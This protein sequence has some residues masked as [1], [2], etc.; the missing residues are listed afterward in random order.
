MSQ[1]EIKPDPDSKQESETR[2]GL[3]TS[4]ENDRQH[5]VK[6]LKIPGRVLN[7]NFKKLLVIHEDLMKLVVTYKS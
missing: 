6:I 1:E 4:K 5:N 7:Q 2:R 3:N